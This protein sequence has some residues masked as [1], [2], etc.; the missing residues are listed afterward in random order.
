MLEPNTQF[1]VVKLP[2]LYN[3]IF[4]RPI[5]Y[6]FE[7]ATKIRYICMKFPID[8]G[9]A[10]MRG[11]HDE[12]KVIYMATIA[13][14]EEEGEVHLEVMQVRDDDKSRELSPLKNLKVLL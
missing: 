14:E 10:I 6:D 1:M 3:T 13:K 7:M 2:L 12:S 9:V 8:R 11:R 5:F 4:K